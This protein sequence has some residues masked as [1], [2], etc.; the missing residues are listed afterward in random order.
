MSLLLGLEDNLV[1]TTIFMSSE[2]SNQELTYMAQRGKFS[3]LDDVEIE[4]PTNNPQN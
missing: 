4:D 1:P 3:K 2:I